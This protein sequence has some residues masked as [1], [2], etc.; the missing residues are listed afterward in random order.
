MELKSR[1]LKTIK[2]TI[3]GLERECKASTMDV[4][5]YWFKLDKDILTLSLL[6]GSKDAVDYKRIGQDTGN[7][8]G[9][10]RNEMEEADHTRVTAL[11][12]GEDKLTISVECHF[13]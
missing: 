4:V 3:N 13:N 5:G 10:W 6:E 11:E 12:I 7:V 2:E 9:V 1:T 8:L